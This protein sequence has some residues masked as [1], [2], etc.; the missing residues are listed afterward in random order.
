MGTV[1]RFPKGN[2]PEPVEAVREEADYDVLFESSRA[3]EGDSSEAVAGKESTHGSSADPR[4]LIVSFGALTAQALSAA[5]ALDADGFH[6]TVVDPHWVVPVADSVVNLTKQVD[7]VI[8]IEDSGLHG[9]AGSKLQMKMNEDKVDT[10]VR[11][12]GIPQRFLAHASRGQVLAELGLDSD[13]VTASA[14]E[15]PLSYRS[16]A[17]WILRTWHHQPPHRGGMEWHR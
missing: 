8:T 9:G 12:L 16:N 2:A 5:Q 6:V 4:V 14:R 13:S 15:W 7:L 10:P 17:N 3:A 11:N 1:V